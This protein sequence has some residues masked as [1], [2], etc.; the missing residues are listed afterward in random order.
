[1][2]PKLRSIGGGEPHRHHDDQGEVGFEREQADRRDL[3]RPEPQLQRA[4]VPAGRTPQEAAAADDPRVDGQPD[5]GR[6]LELD[7]ERVVAAGDRAGVDRAA[8]TPAPSTVALMT[9]PRSA[10]IV[11]PTS[12]ASGAGG[13]LDGD[14]A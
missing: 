9:S 2:N 11:L 7:G 10:L 4:A 13:Q 5:P 3:D 8:R 14:L 12:I 6:R 1:M